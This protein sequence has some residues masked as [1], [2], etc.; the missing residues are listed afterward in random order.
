MRAE[1]VELYRGRWV[2]IRR[3]DD[4]VVVAADS[5]EELQARLAREAHRQLLLRRIPALEDPIFVGLG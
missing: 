5:L 2:A 3:T 1:D 4:I